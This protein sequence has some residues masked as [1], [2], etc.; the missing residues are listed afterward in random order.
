MAL[1][2]RILEID[3]TKGTAEQTELPLE[4]SRDFIG[5]RGLGIRMLWNRMLQGSSSLEPEAE[6][7]VLTGPLTGV[8]P[9]GAHTCL[10]FKSPQ[11]LV[12]YSFTGAQWGQELRCAGYDGLIL[13]GSSPNPVYL[14]I[15]DGQIKFCDA[16]HLWGLTT[17]VTEQF[18]KKE[19]GD[20]QARVLCIGPAGEAQIPFASVQQEYFRSA[21]R[22][23][24]GWFWG[25]KNLKAIVV[26]GTMAI[27]VAHPASA[28]KISQDMHHILQDSRKTERRSYDLIRWG[29]SMTNMPH[30]DEGDLDVANYR[31]GSWDKIGEIGG[32][33]YERNCMAKTRGCYNCPFGCM[34]L[35]IVRQGPFAGKLVC[36]D[37]DSTATIGPGCLVDD[38]NAMVYLSRWAD[39]Q[40]F[41]ATS[42]GNITGFAIE[43][44]E[45][46]IL[47]QSDLDGINLT[48]GNVNAILALW[49]KILKREGIGLILSQG[50]R[51]A[52]AQ[53]GGGSERFAME[54]KGRE[55]AGFTP[56]A[57]HS[58]GIEYVVSDKGPSHHFG[59]KPENLHQ[60]TWSDLLT[61]CTWQRRMITP[62]YYLEL[63]N[64]VTDWDLAFSD[65]AKVAERVLLLG[66]AYNIREGMDPLRDE[67]LPERVH[68]DSLTSGAGKGQLYDRSKFY[69]DRE[70][71]YL[72]NFCDKNGLPTKQ[73][74]E[75][76]DLAFAIPL[77]ERASAKM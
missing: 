26:R 14:L 50:V 6:M 13:K 9:G 12:N 47:T 62:Q 58:R 71:W 65:W 57:H 53:I 63:V 44:Y 18:L 24:S 73:G 72:E 15:K 56:Q 7:Y 27:P 8:A 74:L 39:E 70:S 2:Q 45:N 61:N 22:G 21:A 51:G 28:I 60:R 4:W 1:K 52:A 17:F 76:H 67:V 59:T 66:R 77:M 31:E 49:Q 35:G 25:L 46:N 37:L 68:T 23:G 5:G 69:Q 10:V 16:S 3:L 34:P 11:N 64:A 48:W 32:L 30:S 41:D 20:P 43:C 54:V 42:L 19:T 29:G 75:Q 55:F 33:A 36:P 40:G 38:L